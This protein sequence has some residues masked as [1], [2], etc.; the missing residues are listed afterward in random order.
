[1]RPSKVQGSVQVQ[2]IRHRSKLSPALSWAAGRCSSSS[3]RGTIRAR[4]MW[5]GSCWSR[6]V[7][8]FFLPPHPAEPNHLRWFIP[9]AVFGRRSVGPWLSIYLSY[10]YLDHVAPAA[11]SIHRDKTATPRPRC[12][13]SF[14]RRCEPEVELWA[15]RGL[16]A[17]A[18]KQ[19]GGDCIE[20]KK[21]LNHR[22]DSELQTATKLMLWPYLLRKHSV[23]VCN[24]RFYQTDEKSNLM[25]T[26]GCSSCCPWSWS[27]VRT[28][29]V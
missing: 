1:M 21:D 22:S 3:L 27:V 26:Y 2:P 17:A 28:N 23:F 12:A 10:S 4:S 19:N 14:S 6:Q 8:S 16:Y 7:V 25:A 11:K 20:E 18:S 13:S 5:C 9:P 29:K 15:G 24:A